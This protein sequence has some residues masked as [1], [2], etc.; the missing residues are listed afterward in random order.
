[1]ARWTAFVVGAVSILIAIGLGPNANVAFLVGLAFAVA[2][3]ANLPVILFSLYWKRF[4]TRGA[5]CG[6]A[7]GLLCSVGLILVSPSFMGIDGP[8]VPE[9]ARHMIQAQAL[10]PL[11][12]PGI[13]SIP[14][15]FLAAVI[16]SLLSREPAAEEKFYELSVRANTGLGAERAG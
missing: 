6:L 5:V 1:M 4:T 2:A 10:Y 16:G 11:K 14:L 9:G 13:V 7:A 3:S 8:E 15:G 12:N